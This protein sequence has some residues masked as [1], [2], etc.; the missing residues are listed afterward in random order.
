[1]TKHIHLS[2]REIWGK[3]LAIPGISSVILACYLVLETAEKKI[4]ARISEVIHWKLLARCRDI[5][6]LDK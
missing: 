3:I 2:A 5:T 1:M 4:L 6:R